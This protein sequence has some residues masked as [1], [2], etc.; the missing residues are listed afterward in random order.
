MKGKESDS[1]E[2]EMAAIEVREEKGFGV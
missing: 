2:G 1:E